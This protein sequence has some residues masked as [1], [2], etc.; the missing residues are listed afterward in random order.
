MPHITPAHLHVLLNHIPIVGLPIMAALLIW[1][2]LRREDAVIR[3]ALIG[4]IIVAIGTWGV[5]FTGDPA[6]DDIRHADWF[7]REVVHTHEEAG[8]KTNILAI[9]AGV[10]ALAT[11]VVARGGK[12]ISRPLTF[13]TLL[14]LIFAAMCAA[15]AGWEGGKIRH[16][17]FGNTPAAATA[18]TP[19]AH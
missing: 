6:I 9:V 4:T 10:A 17:E 15:W 19:P 8:D 5:D 16:N 13:V 7:Q 3:V 11:L 18:A 1:G 2:L 12:P 14:L